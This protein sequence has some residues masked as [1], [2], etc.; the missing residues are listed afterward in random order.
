MA[1]YVTAVLAKMADAGA[2]SVEIAAMRRRLG[3]LAETGTGML[4]GSLL[5][6]LEDVP[7]LADL[8]APDADQAHQLFD[9]VAVV[10][11]NGGLGTSMGLSGPKSLLEVKPGVTFL[12]V[13]AM[14]V[15][16]ARESSGARLPLLLMNS[17]TTREPSLQRLAQ[18]PELR[19]PSLPAD[20]LQGREPKLDAETFLPAEW[21]ADPE[22]E[23]CP[24]GHGDIYQ[25]LAATGLLEQLLAEGIR[26]CFVSNSDNLGAAPDV[27]V[28][29]WLAAQDIPFAMEV[30]R[31][32]RSDRKGGHLA[33][34]DGQILLRES[35]QVPDGDDSFGD[36]DR[37]RYFNTNNVWFDLRRLQEMQAEDPSA[38]HLP[39]IVNRKTVDP[40]DRDSTPVIQ[41]ETAM[42]AGI[43]AFRGAQVVEVPR[44]RFAPVKTTNDLLVVRSDAY[45]LEPTGR[46]VREF[47]GDA[48]VV[49]LSKPH[50]G[51]LHDFEA[52]IPSPPSLRNCASLQVDGDVTFGS[53]VTVEG[54]VKIVGPANVPSGEVLR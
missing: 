45:T 52:R 5:Q 53:G 37:W 43:G 13:V 22:L 19:D 14:Q 40:A 36:V 25:A 33:R 50:Y 8:P 29:A 6:P 26:W 31:G 20:F 47:T 9:Q 21:P 10:K 16:S 4:D 42:G 24:P 54:D 12:D 30:V 18:H 51:L 48:P 17:P 15:R 27:R 2:H 35:A 32:T 11:L 3:Q 44:D 1:D 41:L 34:Q 38:P 23:W 7:Q 46:M 39:L 49:T 28:A